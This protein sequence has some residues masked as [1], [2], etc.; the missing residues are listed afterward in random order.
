MT[1]L[2]VAVSNWRVHS[3]PRP[4]LVPVKADGLAVEVDGTTGFDGI[5]Y[6]RFWIVPIFVKLSW[7]ILLCTYC[8]LVKMS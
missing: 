3:Y 5:L 6:E 4:L 7:L 2:T 1:L 8:T